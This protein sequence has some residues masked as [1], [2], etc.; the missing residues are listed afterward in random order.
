MV[1]K[2]CQLLFIAITISMYRYSL[3]HVF[4]TACIHYRMYSLPHVFTTHVFTTACIHYHMYSLPHHDN[5]EYGR[6]LD[7]FSES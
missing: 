4:T 1:V 5:T 2:V 3:P 6:D 7:N